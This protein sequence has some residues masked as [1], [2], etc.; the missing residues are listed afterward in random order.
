MN[1]PTINPLLL[2]EAFKGQNVVNDTSSLMQIANKIDN[3]QTI[4]LG[5]SVLSGLGNNLELGAKKR[6]LV[7]QEGFKFD[8]TATGVS[9]GATIGLNPAVMAATGGL[10]APIGIA[11]G[12][13]GGLAVDTVNFVKN[14]EQFN[15]N[16]YISSML[17][18]QNQ[19]DLNNTD[20][21]GLS[22]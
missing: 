4:A 10:S 5:A 22:I 19:K 15:K 1:Q 2:N 12:A 20:Y 8:G 6:G 7:E 21:T 3:P 11:A 9:L 18:K 13:I 14:K 16:S 17:A